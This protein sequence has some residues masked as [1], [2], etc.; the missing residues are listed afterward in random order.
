MLPAYGC[1]WVHALNFQR[2]AEKSVV[3]DNAYV[4]SMPCAPAR[5]DLHTGRYNF[6][7]RSWGP[8]EPFDDSFIE[9]LKNNNIYTHLV[10]DHQHYFEDGGATYHNRYNSWEFM[11]GQEGDMWKGEVNDPD[12]PVTLNPMESPMHR[13]DWINRKYMPNEEDQSQAKTFKSGLEF[14][15]INHEAE[16]WFLQLETFDP[17]EPFFTHQHYKDLYPHNYEGPHFDWPSYAPVKESKEQVDHVRYEYAALLSMCDHYLGQVLDLMDELNMWK[18]TM[19]I[20]N[21]DHGFLLGEHDWWAKC[22]QP[23]YNEI[24]HIPLFIWDPRSGVRGERRQSLVQMIDMGPTLLEFFDLA[25]PEHMEG[26]SLKDVVSQDQSIRESALFGIHGGHV[27]ITDGRYVYMRAPVHEENEPL[28]NYTLMPT[29]MRNMFS[30]EEMQGM[31]LA[32][33]FPF[34]KGCSTMKIKSGGLRSKGQI[35]STAHKFGTLLF[36]LKAD[37]KQEN[38]IHDKDIEDKMINKMKQQMK[39]NDTPQE[40]YLRLGM[41]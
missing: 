15:R 6:L 20:V 4:G 35:I 19:L 33:P 16:Q 10:T 40:Q 2:L 27:S 12:I 14:I 13:Q 31:T 36:D 21:T 38:P 17:H 22:V 8:L 5:R 26:K 9:I 7:H 23:F 34:T 32:D 39:A 11:R 37:P 28:F 3:F 41:Q 18:D 24:A 25:I 30:I 29:H 1:D